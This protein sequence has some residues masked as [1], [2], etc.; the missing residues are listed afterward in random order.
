M[1]GPPRAV[2]TFAMEI[3][4]GLTEL[5]TSRVARIGQMEEL[6]AKLPGMSEELE[7]IA[8]SDRPDSLSHRAETARTSRGGASSHTADIGGI[9]EL[10]RSVAAQTNLLAALG[11]GHHR[12]HRPPAPGRPHLT[13]R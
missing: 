7:A 4:R 5:M 13:G 11:R 8:R 9:V 12:R 1:P 3:S 10:I 6:S 2:T